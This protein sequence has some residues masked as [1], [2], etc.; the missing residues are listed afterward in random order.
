MV[1]MEVLTVTHHDIQRKSCAS[2]E[3]QLLHQWF[4]V[5]VDIAQQA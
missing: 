3:A 1:T 2:G 4:L 5:S